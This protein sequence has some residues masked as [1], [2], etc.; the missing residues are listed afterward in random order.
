MEK[1]INIVLKPEEA[2]DSEVFTSSVK[3]KSG[4]NRPE[5]KVR[6]LKRSIDARSKHVKINIRALV[7]DQ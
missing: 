4:M 3:K 6:A 5:V 1:L 7:S 2:F